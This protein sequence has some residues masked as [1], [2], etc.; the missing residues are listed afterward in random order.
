MVN[1][2]IVMVV[3]E[4]TSSTLVFVI[5]FPSTYLQESMEAPLN[6]L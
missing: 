2:R 3:D 1:F 5:V 6:I 4:H